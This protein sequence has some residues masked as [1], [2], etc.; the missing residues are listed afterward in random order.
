M[1]AYKWTGLGD[2]QP[3]LLLLFEIKISNYF[4]AALSTFQI[5]LTFTQRYSGYHSLGE[6]LILCLKLRSD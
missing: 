3:Y 1:H 6:I 4:I 5:Y 2:I